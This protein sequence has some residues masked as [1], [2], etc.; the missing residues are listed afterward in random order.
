MESVHERIERKC[1]LAK[2]EIDR[3]K[4]GKNSSNRKSHYQEA[5]LY[6]FNHTQMHKAATHN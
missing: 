6:T 4:S 5:T 3:Q 1:R 2:R